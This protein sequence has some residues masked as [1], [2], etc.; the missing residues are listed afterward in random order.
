VA[1]EVGLSSSHLHRLF[2]EWAGI[3]PKKFLQCL[4]VAHA[5][6][7]LKNG[8]SVLDAALEAG[9]SGPGRLH[10][11]CVRLDGAS[12]GEWKTGGCGWTLRAGFG[13]SPLGACL[14]AEG[15][16]GMCHLSFV[17]TAEEE[18]AWA[19]L[20]SRWPGAALERDDSWAG[21]MTKRIFP[22]VRPPSSRSPLRAFVRGTPF[23]L[24]VWRALLEIPPGMLVS[25]GTL[26]RGIGRPAA[27]RAVGAAVGANPL[28]YLIPCHRVIRETGLP[29]RYRW[30]AE[31]KQAL[32]AW[33]GATTAA[34]GDG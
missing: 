23:Q 10:D 34:P 7:S 18:T 8:S 4:T 21:G 2:A 31:R 14:L 17:E 20:R 28:A 3:T 1:G 13:E 29:G 15:P 26:A 6:E 11:L 27:A 30:G 12:P 33:E 25:Y 32:I 24:L 5:K 16:R 19:D 22:F 9:L